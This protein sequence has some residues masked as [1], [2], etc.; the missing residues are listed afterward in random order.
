MLQAIVE[1]RKQDMIQEE[2]LFPLL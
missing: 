2:K 1:T